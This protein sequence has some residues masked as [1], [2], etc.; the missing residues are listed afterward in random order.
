MRAL[1][2][3]R[4]RD[5]ETCKVVAAYGWL[6]EREFLP[7]KYWVSIKSD[8]YRFFQSR[9]AAKEFYEAMIEQIRRRGRLRHRSPHKKALASL[10]GA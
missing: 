4:L 5:P 10:A 2:Y 7:G 1:C 6:S 3:E 8:P 9:E